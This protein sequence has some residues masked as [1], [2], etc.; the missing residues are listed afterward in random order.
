MGVGFIPR[1]VRLSVVEF[2]RGGGGLEKR[3]VICAD[4]GVW[5]ACEGPVWDLGGGG[6]R[7]PNAG[8]SI[9]IS[10]ITNTSDAIP[11]R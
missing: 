6:S 8:L 3:G 4:Y 9:T 10:P 2:K 7:S 1:K 5:G 11:H